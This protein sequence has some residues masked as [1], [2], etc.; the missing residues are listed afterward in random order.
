MKKLLVSIL[1]ALMAFTCCACGEKALPAL[2]PLSGS[3]E[4][5][6]TEE[7]S[8]PPEEIT[9]NV[10]LFDRGEKTREFFLGVGADGRSFVEIFEEENPGVTLA[11]E[12]APRG[13]MAQTIAERVSGGELPDLV[14]LDEVSALVSDGL[15]MPAAECCAEALYGDFFPSLLAAAGT[16]SG[17]WALPDLVRAEA[18]Y[19]NLDLLAEA[20]V[21]PPESWDELEA[22]CAAISE[23]FGG[24]LRPLGLD[25]TAEGAPRCFARFVW[26]GGGGFLDSGGGWALNSPE[27]ADALGFVFRLA[28][29]DYTNPNPARETQ[30]ALRSLFAEGKLA[31]L[32]DYSELPAVVAEKGGAFGMTAAVFPA[33]EGGTGSCPA[34]L[35]CLAVL[36]DEDASEARGEAVRSFLNMYYAPE[37]YAARAKLEGLLPA[38]RAAAAQYVGTD[39]ALAAWPALLESC[40][41]L[42]SD[43]AG[44]DELCEGL[45]ALEQLSLIG[46]DVPAA[47]DALQSE[48][49]G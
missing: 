26:S 24:E 39:P 18:L 44:W 43:R 21:Q 16:E 13:E 35:D 40:R 19:C 46:G 36:R 42:P 28:G 38:G 49:A 6:A 14:N 2:P 17:A 1:A 32:P 11:L 33:K 34:E 27:N 22:A 45:T 5:S 20:G 9:L 25:M 23:H 37:R 30:R 31:M 29:S 10:I 8:A 3:T 15:L 7:E 41:P 47:L 12:F 48:L 4:E